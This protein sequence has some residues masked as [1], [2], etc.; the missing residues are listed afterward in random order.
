MT[1]IKNQ[2]MKIIFAIE[3]LPGGVDIQCY[4]LGGERDTSTPANTVAGH[5]EK[6]LAMTC[7]LAKE[8]AAELRATEVEAARCW[9]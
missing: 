3:D 4:R 8:E 9:H 1:P 5:I 6:L 7:Q 2:K